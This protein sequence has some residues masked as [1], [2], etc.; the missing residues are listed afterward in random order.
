[1][2][3]DVHGLEDIKGVR[4]RIQ[5]KGDAHGGVVDHAHVDAVAGIAAEDSLPFPGRGL[6]DLDQQKT[7]RLQNM[8][9]QAVVPPVRSGDAQACRI[10]GG[11]VMLDDDV[12]LLRP[13]GRDREAGLRLAP[14]RELNAVGAVVLGPVDDGI[15]APE[16]RRQIPGAGDGLQLAQGGFGE[17]TQLLLPVLGH[18]IHVQQ[19]AVDRDAVFLC[20]LQRLLGGVSGLRAQNGGV[21]AGAEVRHT[22]REQQDRAGE[23]VFLPHTA[24][25]LRRPQHGRADGGVV[26]GAER[27][28]RLHEGLL[29]LHAVDGL[30]AGI[31][32]DRLVKGDHADVVASLGQKSEEEP[33]GV[34]AQ[35]VG[36]GPDAVRVTKTPALIHD[37]HHIIAVGKGVVLLRL[38]GD[39]THAQ[40][41]YQ[42]DG[43]EKGRKQFLHSF[44]GA[45]RPPSSAC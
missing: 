16:G 24:Q 29:V 30:Q 21:A 7:G 37:Q 40:E 14:V 36:I 8:S 11:A 38:G 17:E 31:I 45:L 33:H 4:V 3:C 10:D 44:H 39:G 5:G 6:R 20:H 35:A 18:V 22:V 25:R 2:G 13:E 19:D 41:G 42:K 26:A 1:M 15:E 28:H 32:A 9:V 34:I 43:S 23:A 12:D 27:L